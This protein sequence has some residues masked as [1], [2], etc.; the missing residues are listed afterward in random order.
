[1]VRWFVAIG[2]LGIRGIMK[3]TEVLACFDP[4]LGFHFLVSNGWRGFVLLGAVF[5][6]V[7]GAEALYADVGHFGPKPIRIA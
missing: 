2:L 3:A 1:M 4:L 6:A 5:L 7:T